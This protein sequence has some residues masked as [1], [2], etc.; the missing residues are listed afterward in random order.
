VYIM[1]NHSCTLYIGVTS[2]LARRV[3]QHKH[4]AIK[5]FTSRYRMTKLVYYE[6]RP[7]ISDA[8]AR[9]KQLKRWLR[10]RKMALIESKSP[11]WDDLSGS[12]YG[13]PDSSLRSE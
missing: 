5:G 6:S 3:W 2:D 9:E 1:S 7:A 8:I 10:A 4:K 11:N 12:W 13:E